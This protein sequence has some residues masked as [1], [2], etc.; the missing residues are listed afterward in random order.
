MSPFLLLNMRI[1]LQPL[2]VLALAR[3]RLA[4]RDGQTLVEYALILA[5]L[6][7][8]MVA[9]FTMLGARIVVVFQAI[10]NLLDTA[11]GPPTN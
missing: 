4:R 10:N 8:V 7:V 3:I 9:V 6:T 11:Q 5:I 2:Q 1:L